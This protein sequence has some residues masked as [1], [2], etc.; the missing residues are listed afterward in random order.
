MPPL[1]HL[2]PP[3]FGVSLGIF[4]AKLV[5]SQPSWSLPLEAKKVWE[6]ACH[7]APVSH[8]LSPVSVRIFA[9]L[10]LASFPPPH[11]EAL[12]PARVVV[13]S[14]VLSSPRVPRALSSAS[15]RLRLVVAQSRAVSRA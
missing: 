9:A 15:W 10:F 12:L 8:F 7:Q 14:A 1:S 5:A 11:L 2:L 4:W 6:V 13:M 3:V